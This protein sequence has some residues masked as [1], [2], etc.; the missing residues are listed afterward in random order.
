MSKS[1]KTDWDKKWNKA[2]APVGKPGMRGRSIAIEFEEKVYD[3]L[4]DAS[5]ATGRSIGYIKKHGKV[6]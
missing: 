3:S 2:F 5:R 1:K 4:S 6:L